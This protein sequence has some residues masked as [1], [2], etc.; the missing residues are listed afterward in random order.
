MWNDRARR[1]LSAQSVSSPALT[2]VQSYSAVSW[3]LPLAQKYSGDR[4]SGLGHKLCHIQIDMWLCSVSEPKC[5]VGVFLAYFSHIWGKEAWDDDVAGPCRKLIH[6]WFSLK[7]HSTSAIEICFYR[8]QR[9]SE[10]ESHWHLL[11]HHHEVDICGLESLI[12]TVL[13][14]LALFVNGLHSLNL[15]VLRIHSLRQRNKLF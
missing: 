10:E 12:W 7:S 13:K 14:C 11:W 4:A 8:H 9:C 5:C 15:R 6:R 1:E 3:L 2:D